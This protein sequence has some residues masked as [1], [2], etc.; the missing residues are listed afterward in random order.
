MWNKKD[1][2]SEKY[3]NIVLFCF[4]MRVIK[5]SHIRTEQHAGCGRDV[6]QLSFLK[7]KI[8][9]YHPPEDD[10]KSH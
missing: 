2:I 6:R 8:F 10:A 3:I 1:D 4:V 9:T 7:G 5:L